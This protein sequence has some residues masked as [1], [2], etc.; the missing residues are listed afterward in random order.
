MKGEQNQTCADGAVA[1]EAKSLLTITDLLIGA[2]GIRASSKQVTCILVGG[3]DKQGVWLYMCQ[4]AMSKRVVFERNFG[5]AFYWLA[6][7]MAFPAYKASNSVLC[8]NSQVPGLN[9]ETNL[10]VISSR[11]EAIITALPLHCWDCGRPSERSHKVEASKQ[12][13]KG[14]VTEVKMP[15]L[16][17]LQEQCLLDG[18]SLEYTVQCFSIKNNGAFMH[19][20]GITHVPSFPPSCHPVCRIQTQTC[21]GKR[22]DVS[23]TKTP[24]I[25]KE[26][27]RKEKKFGEEDTVAQSPV[28]S[29]TSRCTATFMDKYHRFHFRGAITGM[30]AGREGFRGVTLK[31]KNNCTCSMKLPRVF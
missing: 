26:I 20:A 3:S 22:H 5:A 25:G 7:L 11:I 17:T 4:Q 21:K 19:S 31:E 15:T 13:A 9:R 18:D 12:R 2:A 6:M 10:G 1:G 29:L 27:E 16:P 24:C 28:T 30:K 8:L 23:N 14:L